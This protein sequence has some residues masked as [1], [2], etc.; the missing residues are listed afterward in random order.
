MFAQLRTSNS[1]DLRLPVLSTASS[2]S[3]SAVEELVLSLETLLLGAVAALALNGVSALPILF[4]S[5][6]RAKLSIAQ[7]CAFFPP[8]RRN[9]FQRII[10]S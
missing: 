10:S 1:H 5:E 8:V 3:S 6:V 9:A 4:R 7:M 2:H